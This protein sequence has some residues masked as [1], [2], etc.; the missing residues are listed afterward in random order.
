MAVEKVGEKY[1]CFVCGNMVVV[2]MAGG[3]TWVCCDEEMS[4]IEEPPSP[5][6]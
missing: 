3:G 1:K 6:S 5:K 2:T 4:R